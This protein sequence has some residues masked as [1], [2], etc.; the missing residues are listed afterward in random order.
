LFQISPKQN[1]RKGVSDLAAGPDEGSTRSTGIGTYKAVIKRITYPHPECCLGKEFVLLP[2]DIKLRIPV[3]YSGR[4]KLIEYSNHQ[5]RQNGKDDVVQR[6]RP[7]FISNLAGEIIEEGEL[8]RGSGK[9]QGM[10]DILTQN[11]VM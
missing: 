8:K 7:W 2:K 9:I 11:W 6:Q 1:D 3:Q 5:G 4:N 10:T